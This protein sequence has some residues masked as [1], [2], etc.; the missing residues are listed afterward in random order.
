MTDNANYIYEIEY[1]REMDIA[2]MLR[3]CGLSAN[4]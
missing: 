1:E 3:A 2:D 4:R